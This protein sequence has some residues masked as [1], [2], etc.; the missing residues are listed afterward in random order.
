MIMDVII[1]PKCNNTFSINLIN[2]LDEDGETYL[3]PH[4][5]YIIRYARL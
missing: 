3:C 4:C 5:K 1:C 2:S